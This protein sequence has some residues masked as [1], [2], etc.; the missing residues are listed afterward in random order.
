MRFG[1]LIAF[2]FL[3]LPV[4]AQIYKW[5]DAQGKTFST[6]LLRM[7]ID[8]RDDEADKLGL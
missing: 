8:V 2:A 6:A 3:S 7:E 1:L 5:T 4:S